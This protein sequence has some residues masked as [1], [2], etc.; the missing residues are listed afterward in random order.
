MECITQ[1]CRTSVAQCMSLYD[2]QNKLAL[3]LLEKRSLTNAPT[4]FAGCTGF[5]SGADKRSHVYGARWSKH[6]S[7][8][9]Q[10]I[11]FTAESDEPSSSMNHDPTTRTTDSTGWLCPVWPGSVFK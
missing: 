5:P 10:S 1:V 9:N 11:K 4:S 8:Q 7:T 2:Y 3:K 6:G